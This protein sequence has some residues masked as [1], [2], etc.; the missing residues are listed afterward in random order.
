MLSIM[1]PLAPMRMFDAVMADVLSDAH[2]ARIAHE[3]PHLSEHDDK[4][5][6][7]VEAPGV[8]AADLMVE[9]RSG[10]MS[11]RGETNSAGHRRFVN[12][13]I[14]L[15][16]DADA[17][18]AHAEHADGLITVTV[19]KKEAKATLIAVSAADA[20]RT[21]EEEEDAS[22]SR[23][24]K[25]TLVAAGVA[26]ADLA[27]HVEHGV[28]EVKGETKRTGACLNRSFRLP[29]DADTANARAEHIDGILTVTIPKK[30]AVEAKR[31]KLIAPAA[32]M[33]VNTE[34]VA[35]EEAVMVTDDKM[36]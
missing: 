5:V 3:A 19:P 22:E 7:H 35:E 24:Y 10:K 32:D 28:L 6:V 4:Y 34:G 8:A 29:R 20:E 17:D 1:S 33:Q 15:P 36:A 2:C 9:T 21:D 18:H 30:L 27:L 14:A 11:I 16:Q 12:Y 13:S 26:P 23:P 31:I 25:L